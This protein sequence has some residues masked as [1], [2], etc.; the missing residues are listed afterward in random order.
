M[1]PLKPDRIYAHEALRTNPDAMVRMERFLGAMGRPATEV[2]WFSPEEAIRVSREVAGW[3]PDTETAD[4]KLRQP[5]V[6]TN[7]ALEGTAAE[8]P[9]IKGRPEGEAL[10]NLE[11]VLGYLPAFVPHHT[12]GKDAESG[13]VCW[14]SMFLA[15]VNGCSHGCVYC[16]AGRGG[17]ALIV[18]LNAVMYK[19]QGNYIDLAYK[20]V[21]LIVTPLFSL[22]FMALFVRWA[23]PFGGIW[24]ALY[25]LTTVILI[26]FWNEITGLEQ[27]SIQ[28]IAPL[29]LIVS[30][31]AGALLS[32]L[33]TKGRHP[34]IV[35]AWSLVAALPLLEAI[36]SAIYMGIINARLSE[37]PEVVQLLANP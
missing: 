33:P 17:K 5:V 2:D 36:R 35:V 15:S 13:M 18:A 27:L 22:F 10:F 20:T 30:I 9:V 6:F 19:I 28:W 24:G 14:P 34:G 7:F 8:D 23:T 16:G 25:G 21:N 26:A 11:Q 3:T 12:P 4:W 29:G 32:L 31:S 1:Y 37:L